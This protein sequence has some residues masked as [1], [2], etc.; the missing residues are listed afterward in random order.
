MIELKMKIAEKEYQDKELPVEID[1]IDALENKVMELE[2]KQNNIN[3]SA[4]TPY[5]Q[6]NLIR[7]QVQLLAADISDYMLSTAKG[8]LEAAFYAICE[9]GIDLIKAKTKMKISIL[10]QID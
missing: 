6:Q 9:E 2:A 4:L 7:E 3:L 5:V 1:R 8:K 10:Q